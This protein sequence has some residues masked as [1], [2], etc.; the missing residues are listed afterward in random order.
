MVAEGKKNSRMVKRAKKA[1][2]FA[3]LANG[4]TALL[5]GVLAKN[6]LSAK[7]RSDDY[8]FIRCAQCGEHSP[9]SGENTRFVVRQWGIISG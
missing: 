9:D 3:M 2:S 5:A 8:K 6:V 1:I 7:N 4:L